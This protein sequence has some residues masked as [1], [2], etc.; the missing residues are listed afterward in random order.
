MA[1]KCLKSIHHNYNHAN[2]ATNTT[3]VSFLP[4][5]VSGRNQLEAHPVKV[6]M[7]KG[8]LAGQGFIYRA[9]SAA[10]PAARA[11]YLSLLFC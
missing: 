11:S 5:L 2:N 3:S 7:A 9:F 4:V 1:G 6:A 8:A 10:A